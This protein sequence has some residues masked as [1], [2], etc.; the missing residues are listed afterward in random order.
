[1]RAAQ[2]PASSTDRHG[3]GLARGRRPL[4]VCVASAAVQHSTA[5]LLADNASHD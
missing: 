2:E 5:A 1:M 4:L 3:K